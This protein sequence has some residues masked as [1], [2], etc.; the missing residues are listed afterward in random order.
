LIHKSAQR[1]KSYCAV[2]WKAA[3]FLSLSMHLTKT[4]TSR[5]S[6]AAAFRT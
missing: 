6:F 1:I 4:A 5:W 2:A 3:P